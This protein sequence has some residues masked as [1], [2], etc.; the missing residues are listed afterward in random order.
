[1]GA[2]ITLTGPAQNIQKHERS[3]SFAIAAGPAT[4]HPPEGLELFDKTIYQVECTPEQ[5]RRAHHDPQD[6]SDMIVRGY[7]EPRRDAETGQLYVAV[8]ATELETRRSYEIRRL[9]KL[10]AAVEAARQAFLA[11]K[12]AAAPRQLLEARAAAFVKASEKLESFV[13]K[14]P[15]VNARSAS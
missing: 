15:G 1:M 12:E 9:Q 11:A 8:V 7:I 5:W 2:K 10:Q 3:V 14:H 13:A 6:K 4:R